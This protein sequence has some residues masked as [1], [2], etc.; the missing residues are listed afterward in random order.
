MAVA[1][2][3]GAAGVTSDGLSIVARQAVARAEFLGITIDELRKSEPGWFD[4]D[5]LPPTATT[6]TP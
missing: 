4:Y 6:T 3:E 1:T 5:P 2:R